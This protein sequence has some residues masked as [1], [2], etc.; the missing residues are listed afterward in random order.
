MQGLRLATD[1]SFTYS[2]WCPFC[3]FLSIELLLSDDERFPSTG[4]MLPLAAHRL[5]CCLS[6]ISSKR[7]RF[8]DLCSWRWLWLRYNVVFGKSCPWHRT[9]AKISSV[10]PQVDSNASTAAAKAAFAELPHL[11]L[12]CPQPA[13]LL[14][15]QGRLLQMPSANG[16]LRRSHIR[17]P[18]QWP[19]TIIHWRR[20]LLRR[21][22]HL[23]WFSANIS[24]ITISEEQ[25]ECNVAGH[26][27][28]AA[29][30]QQCSQQASVP[31][32]PAN[33]KSLRRL[34]T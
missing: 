23:S 31:A 18:L 16:S 2:H 4:H 15:L 3:H 13:H 9:D 7:S 26:L 20:S 22:S 10:T 34:P 21:N 12:P 28:S 30:N 14:L 25:F 32:V 29:L 1:L 8:I 11:L 19:W 27:H 17:R 5:L 6:S 33:S 24:E